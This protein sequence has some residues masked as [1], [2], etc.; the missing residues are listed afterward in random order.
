MATS[1][2][3]TFVA[4]RYLVASPRHVSRLALGF[5]A[6]F[7][8]AALALGAL[9]HFGMR[10]PNPSSPLDP[11]TPHY[12]DWLV[13]RNVF[14]GLAIACAYLFVVRLLLTFYSTVSVMGLTIG[15]AAL[16]IVL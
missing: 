13:V 4:V 8:V 7:L 12:G 11:S 3:Q 10:A 14:I 1:R 5:V 16:V 15:G 2:F 9:I 6:F